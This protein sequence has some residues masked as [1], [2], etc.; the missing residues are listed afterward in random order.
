VPYPA[1]AK[2]G[3]KPSRVWHGGRAAVVP[4]ILVGLILL[5]H[6]GGVD[7]V[8]D[9]EALRCNLVVTHTQVSSHAASTCWG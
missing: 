2:L 5:V 1:P 4:D 9:R 6:N 3:L 7:F 8:Q